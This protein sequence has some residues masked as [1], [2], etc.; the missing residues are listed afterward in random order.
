MWLRF[1]GLESIVV[2]SPTEMGKLK[3]ASNVLKGKW[4]GFRTEFGVMARYTIL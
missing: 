2:M 1:G 4:F 3:Y